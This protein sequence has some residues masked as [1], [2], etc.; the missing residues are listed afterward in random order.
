MKIN[1]TN[2]RVYL[3]NA[4]TNE[5]IAYA[6]ECNL[7]IDV[8]MQ[9][10]TDKSNQGF[11]DLLAGVTSWSVDTS[12]LCT[13]DQ[14]N[15]NADELTRRQLNKERVF[16]KIDTVGTQGN[17]FYYWGQALIA[18]LSITSTNE[19]VVTMTMTLEGYR[20]L[21]QIIRGDFFSVVLDYYRADYSDNKITLLMSDDD[22]IEI[23]SLYGS[24]LGSFFT[25]TSTQ[26]I[27]HQGDNIA[28]TRNNGSSI[29]VNYYN[30]STNENKLIFN[31]A[32]VTAIADIKLIGSHVL[33]ID[34]SNNRIYWV[35]KDDTISTPIGTTGKT[36]AGKDNKGFYFADADDFYFYSYSDILNNS[37]TFTKFINAFTGGLT[38]F[39]QA[40]QNSTY[41]VALSNEAG[42]YHLLWKNKITNVLYDVTLTTPT[43]AY[44]LLKD[45]NEDIIVYSPVVAATNKITKYNGLTRQRKGDLFTQDDFPHYTMV[46]CNDGILLAIG[47]LGQ[48]NVQII[49]N[50][51]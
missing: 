14:G 35:N 16:I 45:D 3:D 2:L 10:A 34:T 30:L 40:L 49:N 26:L 19:D 21:R 24:L 37:T 17:T 1:G 20:S 5:A 46:N 29:D 9:E 44:K 13:F 7:S 15:I 42:V 51:L 18:N 22:T 32:A 41:Y 28:F 50:V 8:S 31:N 11:R 25:G 38:T 33:F 12:M 39:Y 4:S 47:N 6:T 48:T 23:Y 36:Y 27:S 43:V